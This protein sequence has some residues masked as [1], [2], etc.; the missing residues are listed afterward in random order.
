MFSTI[1]R[2]KEFIFQVKINELPQEIPFI[3]ISKIFL[4]LNFTRPL[5]DRVLMK[6][7]ETKTK[8]FVCMS[9]LTHNVSWA[10]PEVFKGW[11]S[12]IPKRCFYPWP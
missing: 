2:V 12:Q 6:F 4:T 9:I 7:Y 5:L 11:K 3:S 8:I 10:W 1:F